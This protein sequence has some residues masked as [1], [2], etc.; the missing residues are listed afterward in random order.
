MKL[1]IK[2]FSEITIKSSSV[3]I[4]FIKILFN[5][6]C[7]VLK[8]YDKLVRIYYFWDYI[9]VLLKKHDDNEYKNILSVLIN[10]P[11]IQTILRIKEHTWENISDIYKKVFNLYRN[12]LIGKT[13][14][15]RVKRKGKH[16][17]TSQDIEKYIGF[18]LNR[19]IPGTSVNL[20][21]P[22]YLV[23]LQIIDNKL[24]LILDEIRGLGG[25]PIGTQQSV[26]SLI[27]GGFDSA[28]AS[29]MLI[30]R[31]CRV[32]YCFFN[33]SGHDNEYYVRKIVYHL[34]NTFGV[35]HSVFFIS[36]NFVSVIDMM[37]QNISDSQIGIVLKR[38]MIRTASILAKKYNILSLLTGEVLGQV[39]SQT[40]TNLNIINR[41]SDSLVLRPLIT[42]SKDDIINISRK[43]GT[44]KYSKKVPEYCGLLYKKPTVH[45]IENIVLKE[46]NKFD[47]S[48]L[49]H[50]V[51]RKAKIF[52]VCVIGKKLKYE[53][54]NN[55][56][57]TSIIGNNDVI[58]DI[59]PL[60]RM[61]NKI[62]FNNKNLVDIKVIPFHNLI[63]QFK[64]L[65]QSKIYLLY[66]DYGFISKIHANCLYKKGFRNIKIYRPFLD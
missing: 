24:I 46:E 3:R 57:V 2:F 6:I 21:K 32:N 27:S 48:I 8:K 20:T 55:I 64:K 53:N 1:I 28:V 44:E 36:L 33:F 11:G 16:N 45:A 62:L 35:S 17:F 54:S 31:G 61:K 51:I 41:V 34:W 19:D 4:S 18:C 14:C 37:L 13:F 58:L 66:C 39:S 5:N 43:I 56:E 30:K 12:F 65:D 10:I 60:D 7:K 9:E 23:L 25:F 38:M 22:E 49:L 50:D 15:V 40:M 52:D 29:Y 42:Y 47:F 63:S 59:R 26:L